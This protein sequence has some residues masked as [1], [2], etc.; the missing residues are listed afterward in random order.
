MR[1]PAADPPVTIEPSSGT[2]SRPGAPA[3]VIVE[4][5]GRVNLIGEHTDY[6]GGLV[7]PVAIDRRIRIEFEPTD[8]RRIELTL[9][10]T[11][12]TGTVELDAIERAGRTRERAG[13]WV[14]YVAGTAWSMQRA[15][16]PTVGFR[17][18][19]SSDLPIG[20]GLSSSA[21]LEIAVAWALSHGDRPAA[22]GLDLAR[23]ARAAEN[24]Y[25]GVGSGLMDPAA[26]IL[27]AADHALLLDCRSL[28]HRLVRLP[29]DVRIVV[30]DS[31]APRA[32]ATSEYNARRAEC[33]AAVATLSALD[34]TVLSLR[35]VSL[36]RL[37]AARS[38][39][40]DRP[41]RRARHVVTENARVEAVVTALEGGDLGAV[42]G[43]MRASHVSLRDDFEVSSDALDA[44][45]EIADAV[46]GVVGARLTGAG[47]GGCVVVLIEPGAERAVRTVVERDYP[48]RTGLT[49][50]VMD[51][52]PSDGAG[53]VR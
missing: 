27:G 1:R 3:A 48:A 12:E 36:D 53:R 47:F 26:V 38:S 32:L 22:D 41:F 5:P 19:L 34:P 29:P 37:E 23:I 6:N 30:I 44:L 46:P 24:E 17:G 4:A 50:V 2:S 39:L 9:E 33:E 11:G 43:A 25:I 7:L 28:E 45:V 13:G 31:G 52:R 20:A 21:A 35:D 16:L 18:R 51:V 40:G 15:G 8:D 14:D 49:P 10:A 42:G